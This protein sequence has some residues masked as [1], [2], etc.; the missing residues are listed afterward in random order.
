MPSKLKPGAEDRLS[1]KDVGNEACEAV[2]QAEV[3]PAE[4][5]KEPLADTG[6]DAAVKA[7]EAEPKAAWD[8]DTGSA[9]YSRE[10][11]GMSDVLMSGTPLN[12]AKLLK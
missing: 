7:W 6:P 9:E 8:T 2:S 3:R 5:L 12:S 11:V 1:E 4:L 10:A